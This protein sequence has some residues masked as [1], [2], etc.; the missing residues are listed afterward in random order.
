MSRIAGPGARD[1]PAFGQHR[2]AKDEPGTARAAAAAEPARRGLELLDTITAG[3]FQVGLGLQAAMNLRHDAAGQRIA[4]ALGHLDG[5][6]RE[7]RDTAFSTRDRQ[8]PPYPVPLDGA[9]R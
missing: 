5:T 6:L 3:F 2:S 8:A 9:G 7:I 4:E 1:E